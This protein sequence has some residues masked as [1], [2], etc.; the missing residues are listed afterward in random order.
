MSPAEKRKATIIEKW[1]SVEAFQ[2]DIAQ[3]RKD[4]LLERLGSEEAVKDYYATM[5]K[6]S[7]TNYKKNG[8]TGGFRSLTPEKLKAISSMGGKKSRKG[9]KTN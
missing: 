4:T 8:S 7:R 6:K 1:G 3:K 5:Q 2:N 9:E